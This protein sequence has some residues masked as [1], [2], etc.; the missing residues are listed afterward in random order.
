LPWSAYDGKTIRLKQSKTG[1]RV[2][3]PIGAPLKAML[4]GMKKRGPLVLTTLKGRA[5]TAHGFQSSWRKARSKAG[6]T[7]LTFH[8]LRGTAVTR[9]SVAGA[10]LQEIATLTG[11]SLRDVQSILDTN[12]L[13]RDLAMAESAIKKLEKGTQSSN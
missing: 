2:T 12:Y 3:V 5:W 1:V 10:T 13:D 8:D 4:D 7:G 9:F 11:H 6:I